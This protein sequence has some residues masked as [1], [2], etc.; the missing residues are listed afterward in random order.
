MLRPCI[1][2]G[3]TEQPKLDEE[4]EKMADYMYDFLSNTADEEGPGVLT[5]IE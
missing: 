1:I 3:A 4:K 5:D 2:C